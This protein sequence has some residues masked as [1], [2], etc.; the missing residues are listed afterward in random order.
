MQR[1]LEQSF[2][3]KGHKMKRHCFVYTFLS[4][5][6]IYRIGIIKPKS[7]LTHLFMLCGNI[8][9]ELHMRATARATD[10]DVLMPLRQSRFHLTHWLTVKHGR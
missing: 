10:S 8:D 5:F 3:L 6:L 2:K 4:S 1:G 9:T 7:L